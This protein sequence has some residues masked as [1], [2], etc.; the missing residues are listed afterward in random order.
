M[1]SILQAAGWTVIPLLLCSIVALALMVERF[2]SLRK[3]RV[4]PENL[5]DEV[6]S[7]MRAGLP[8]AETLDKL[9]QHS[10]L[11]WVLAQGLMA[12]G[13]TGRVDE[14]QLKASFE[15]AGRHAVHGMEKHLNALGT[16]AR[17]APLLGLVGTVLGMI[18]IFGAS[19][20]N[21]SGGNPVELAHGI[22]VALYNTAMGLIVA[23]PSLM[24][25]RHFRARVD[26]HTL[27]LEQCAE[28]ILPHILRVTGARR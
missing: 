26:D 3:S 1:L 6:V 19:S 8:G 18:E 15:S 2:I 11:G 13:T 12:A 9:S 10:I 17:A 4:A 23:I 25:Y 16:I 27:T 7:V 28:R 20:A 24:A 14:A 5:V 22:S 21:A